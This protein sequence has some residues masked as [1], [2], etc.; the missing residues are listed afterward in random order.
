MKKLIP[1]LALLLLTSCRSVATA[2]SPVKTELYEKLD[3]HLPPPTDNLL[4]LLA[5]LADSSGIVR[6]D[7]HKWEG[8]PGRQW[9]VHYQDNDPQVHS[10]L[11]VYVY[12]FDSPQFAEDYLTWQQ[13][14][15]AYQSKI[16]QISAYTA[17]LAEPIVRP[18]NT[19][20]FYLPEKSRTLQ[21]YVRWDYLVLYFHEHDSSGQSCG[22]LTAANLDLLADILAVNSE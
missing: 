17:V 12:I 15:S 21:T 22:A 16:Q 20:S 14:H 1:L 4:D 3:K 8:S 11:D 6:Y 19:D 7:S 13:N 5:V 10:F 9:L 18:G 2:P